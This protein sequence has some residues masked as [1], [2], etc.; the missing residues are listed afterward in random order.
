[1]SNEK[2]DS[3]QSTNVRLNGGNYIYWA[4]VMKKILLGKDVRGYVSGDITKPTNLTDANYN[5]LIVTWNRNNAKIITWINNSVDLNI[6]M[7]LAKFDT[8]KEVWDY[9]TTL[10]SQSNFAKR[11]KLESDIRD[12]RQGDKDIQQFYSLMTSYWDQLALTEPV[13]LRTHN[14]YIK[15]REEQ[16]LVQFLMALRDDFEALRGSILHRSPLPSVDSGVS[17][18]L[19]EEL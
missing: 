19:A 9:L 8:C 10:F 4:Y 11:Y 16:R 2:D 14:P 5:T 1:M 12:A 3:L 13:D 18:L 7:H 6:G 15:Y 17:E